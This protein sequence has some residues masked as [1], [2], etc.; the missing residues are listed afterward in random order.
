[1]AATTA[2]LRNEIAQDLERLPAAQLRKVREYVQLLRFQPL[3]G[4]VDP[5]Q[6][7]HLW[8]AKEQAAGRPIPEGQ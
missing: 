2:T 5:D 8:R 6:V 4:K 7:W 3:V 1:M